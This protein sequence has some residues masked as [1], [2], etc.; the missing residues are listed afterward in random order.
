VDDLFSENMQRRVY[1]QQIDVI[2]NAPYVVGMTPWILFDFRSPRRLNGFQAGFN[3]KGLVAA[4]RI[5][6][7]LAFAT[8]KAFYA[9][10]H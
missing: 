4:D 9:S 6:R 1:E 2:G 7:K 5:T 3:R 10:R 8:L